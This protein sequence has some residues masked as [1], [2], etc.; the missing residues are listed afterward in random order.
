VGF[1]DAVDSARESFMSKLDKK[2]LVD[3]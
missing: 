2:I 3:K 1:K